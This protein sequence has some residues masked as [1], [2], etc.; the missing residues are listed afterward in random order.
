MKIAIPSSGKTLDSIVAD[1]FARAE[2]FIIYDDVK[3]DYTVVP[4]SEVGAHGMGPKVVQ[5]LAREG[6]DVLIIPGM[7]RNAF[8]ATVA[9]GIKPYMAKPGTVGQNIEWFKQGILE[10]LMSPRKACEK[11][12]DL[13]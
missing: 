8:D 5:M 6:A 3:N 7:G 2:Y 4:N 10:E 12:S 1:R 9:A 13:S 11:E